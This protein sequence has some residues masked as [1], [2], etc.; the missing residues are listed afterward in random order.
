MI[1]AIWLLGFIALYLVIYQANVKYIDDESIKR[2]IACTFIFLCG[3][4]MGH[5]LTSLAHTIETTR[6]IEKEISRE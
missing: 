1:F 6:L 4:V 5:L 2:F 3:L